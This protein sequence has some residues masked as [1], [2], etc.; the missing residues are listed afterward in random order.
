M[1]GVPALA[2]TLPILM[3][4]IIL[5]EAVPVVVPGKEFVSNE[6]AIVKF[7]PPPAICVVTAGNV[8]VVAPANIVAEPLRLE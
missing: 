8:K 6:R 3:V 1:A 5:R 7:L 4:G 2:V